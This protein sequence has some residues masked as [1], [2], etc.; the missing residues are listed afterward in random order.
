MDIKN[1][2]TVRVG[3]A[4]RHPKPFAVGVAARKA[5]PSMKGLPY[6]PGWRQDDYIRGWR[7]QDVI[8]TGQ[9]LDLAA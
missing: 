6:G 4:R 3:D 2:K 1:K 9:Q 8:E 5:G 7:H